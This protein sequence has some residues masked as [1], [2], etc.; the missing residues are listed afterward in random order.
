MLFSTPD[1]AQRLATIT[2]PIII[3]MEINKIARANTGPKYKKS[4]DIHTTGNSVHRMIK[5]RIL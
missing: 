5:R 4:S 1:K 2:V 3:N